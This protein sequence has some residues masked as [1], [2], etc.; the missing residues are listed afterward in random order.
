MTTRPK[1]PAH[2]FLPRMTAGAAF[3]NMAALGYVHT[4]PGAERWLLREDRMVLRFMGK[5]SLLAAAVF[6]GAVGLAG[7]AGAQDA[8]S[9]PNKPVRVIVPFGAGGGNDI[10]ARLVT[11]KLTEMTGT[12]VVIENRPAAGGRVAA[13]FVAKSAPDGY[14]IFVGASGVMSIAT[15]VF[16][17]LNYHP[18]KSFV[19]LT[20]IASFPLIMIGN[21]DVP[22]KTVKEM[23]EYSKANPAKSNYGTTSPAFT[24]ATELLKLKS[25]M[26]AVLVPLKSSAE[27]VQCVMRGDCSI[28]L[29]DTPPAVP[30]IK[31]GRV[32]ALAVTGAQRSPLLPDVPSMSEAGFPDVNTRLW[33]G[34]FAPAATPPAI[35]AKLEDMLRKA[36]GEKSVNER[37]VGMAVTPGGTTGAEFRKM[38]DADIEA[39]VAVMKA[40]NLKFN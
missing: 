19:P 34:F 4:R 6:A 40:A 38:I 2:G 13:D 37:L 35:T 29:V 39:Y 30:Q 25:G 23:V 32:R 31:E 26:P 17:N 3:C 11:A 7:P 36:I 20:M 22:A 28:A 27:M 14:T 21:N 1:A 8:A 5:G 9:F 16:P 24:M 33:S 10:F 12:Q 18:T 15:A